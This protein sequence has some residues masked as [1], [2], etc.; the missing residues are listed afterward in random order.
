MRRR[1]SPQSEHNAPDADF[2]GVSSG[3]RG[4]ILI[5]LRLSL[6]AGAGDLTT[7]DTKG[8]EEEKRATGCNTAAAGI[9]GCGELQ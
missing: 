5:L 1:R 3:Y 7:E 9:S 4:L 8:T 6:S 2:K